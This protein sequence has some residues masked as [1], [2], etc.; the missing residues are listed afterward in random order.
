MTSDTP[1]ERFLAAL[2]QP[3]QANGRGL[4]ARCPA[5]DDRRASLSITEADDGRVLLRCFAGCSVNAIVEAVGLEVRDLFP[6]REHDQAS[7]DFEATYDYRDEQGALLSQVVRFAG[8][9]F[10]QRRPDGAGG[11]IWNLQNVRRVLYRLPELKGHET[12]LVVEGEKDVESLRGI[13]V[14]ATCNIGGAGK[15]RDEYAEQLKV[16]G[17]K[18]VGVVPDNDPPGEAHA[19]QVARSCHDAGLW[20]KLLTLPDVPPKGDISDW[21]RGHTR[22]D[23]V[24]LVQTAPAFDPRQL[25]A[26]APKLT[27]TSIADFLAEPEDQTEWLVNQRI[28][29]GGVVLLAGTPKA[30]KSTLAR[31]LL[32]AVTTGGT[33]LGWRVQY[34][35]AW[36]ISLEDKRSE[37]RKAFRAMG[38]TADAPL[39]I[40]AGQ[41]PAGLLEELSALAMRERPACIVVDTLQRLIRS[42][43]LSDYAEVT[44]RFAPLLKLARDTGAALILVH[45]ASTHAQREG[46]LD[47]VLGSTAISGSV[48]QVFLLRRTEKYRTLASVQ[49]IGV[50]LEPIV[51]ERDDATGLVRQVCAKRDADEQEAATHILDAMRQENA[52]AGV[53][54][55][56]IKNHVEGRTTDLPRALRA[57]LRR[58]QV[59]R[60]GQGG[61]RDP[62]RYHLPGSGFEVSRF[63]V[64]TENLKPQYRNRETG[65]LGFEVSGTPESAPS[66]VVEEPDNPRKTES[67]SGFKNCPDEDG[68]ERV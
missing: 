25:V 13:G 19:R 63:P 21:L 62:Y 32:F 2:P 42:R 34:G 40:F 47:A 52:E 7:E 44:E 55:G 20:V 29:A 45:H 53:T 31:N 50:D 16:A 4:A 60:S 8:K 61:K 46:V 54:E 33:W 15:W 37:I 49:R 1:L 35:A 68:Y 6:P 22:E 18:N 66:C 9:K 48:D 27:M 26:A 58:G 65:D 12:V 3:A 23:L 10:R 56:W 39:S 24:A 64:R 43:D 51:I 11:W 14:T 17:V 38:I 41:P 67:D 30:G 36:Y 57:L 59:L 28:P 5:H